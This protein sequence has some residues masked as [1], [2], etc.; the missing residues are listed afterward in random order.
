MH[1][2]GFARASQQPACW[3]QCQANLRSPGVEN[4]HWLNV[5]RFSH[6]P[7]DSAF[8]SL[9]LFFVC[10]FSY[11]SAR[12][13]FPLGNFSWRHGE[14]KNWP[15]SRGVAIHVTSV[16]FTSTKYFC[17]SLYDH[18]SLKIKLNKKLFFFF[19]NLIYNNYNNNSK[20]KT[21]SFTCSSAILSISGN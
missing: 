13:F 1:E 6:V 17:N 14:K 8:F 4:K 21:D 9:C 11:G 10:F 18:K 3:P 12:G 2:G 16:C 15:V 7:I 20:P 19:S 5:R